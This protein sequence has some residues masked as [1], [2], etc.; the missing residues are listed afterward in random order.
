MIC[1]HT[2]NKDIFMDTRSAESTL[3]YK[4]IHSFIHSSLH[5]TPPSLSL[6]LSLCHLAPVHEE[7]DQTADGGNEAEAPTKCVQRV[8]VLAPHFEHRRGSHE[9]AEDDAVPLYR[10]HWAAL[11]ELE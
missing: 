11:P 3:Q 4:N 6:A 7:P 10:Q 2:V 1:R 5:P 9:R 8:L